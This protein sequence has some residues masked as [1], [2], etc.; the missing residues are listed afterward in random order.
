VNFRSEF[1][2]QL[3]DEGQCLGG[4]LGK[5]RRPEYPAYF[6]GLSP[7]CEQ[8]FSVIGSFITFTVAAQ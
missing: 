8:A 4:V 3:G 2:R 5:V 6:H 1:L 7:S